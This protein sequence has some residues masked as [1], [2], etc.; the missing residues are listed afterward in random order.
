MGI[1]DRFSKWNRNDNIQHIRQLEEK[2]DKN[3]R[4]ES[5]KL[6]EL[7][8]IRQAETTVCTFTFGRYTGKPQ[9]IA[10]EV[11]QSER[12]HG[13]IRKPTT[14]RSGAAS[15]SR[16][17]GGTSQTHEGTE[18]QI[19]RDTTR[20]SS[21]PSILA[22]PIQLVHLIESE[23]QAVL[24]FQQASDYH[25]HSTYSAVKQIRS[26]VRERLL[27]NLENFRRAYGLIAQHSEG[28]VH[29]AVVAVLSRSPQVWTR[30]HQGNQNFPR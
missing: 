5:L 9:A 15:F 27:D 8:D 12:L 29:D 14:G 2:L 25:Q 18:K 17:I 4:S 6:R 13:W 19:R 20:S 7:L 28:W 22:D 1:S 23:S 26:D 16:R 3:K 21:T 10:D 11:R 24:Q 30:L